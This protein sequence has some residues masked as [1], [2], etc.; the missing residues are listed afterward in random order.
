M[1]Y[2]CR[3][4]GREISEQDLRRIIQVR[5]GYLEGGEFYAESDID[6]YHEGCES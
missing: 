5:V 2:L 4:C 1:G 6:Y 3:G